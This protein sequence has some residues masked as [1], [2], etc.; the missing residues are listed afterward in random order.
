MFRIFRDFSLFRTIF[1]IF[2][3]ISLYY[4]L[5]ELAYIGRVNFLLKE[6]IEYKQYMVPN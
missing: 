4:I 2:L 6:K 5:I 1:E 3:V